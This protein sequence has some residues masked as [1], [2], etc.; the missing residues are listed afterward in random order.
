[1]KK[2]DHDIYEYGE[3]ERDA[4]RTAQFFNVGGFWYRLMRWVERMAKGEREALIEERNEAR[5][6]EPTA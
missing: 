4:A 5:A 2:I 6:K 1:M 3:V